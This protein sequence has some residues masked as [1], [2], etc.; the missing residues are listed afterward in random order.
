[1]ISLI[2]LKFLLLMS[3]SVLNVPYEYYLIL[4]EVF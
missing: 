1:M 2:P 4:L 3:E